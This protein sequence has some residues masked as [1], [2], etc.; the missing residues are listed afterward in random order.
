[1]LP[2]EADA[3]VDLQGV[4]SRCFGRVA[5]RRQRRTGVGPSGVEGQGRPLDEQ[6]GYTYGQLTAAID[7]GAAGLT[8]RGLGRGDVVVIFSPNSPE[9]PVVFH[10]V[11][12]VGAVASP[13]NALY[14][15]TE[16]AHQLRDAGARVLFTS[17]DAL[18]R[19]RKS[20]VEA[21]VRGELSQ[22][23]QPRER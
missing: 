9:Y 12:S 15:P 16:L 4:G 14:T 21:N 8:E 3:A 1:M 7:R 13:A 10:G 23:Q 17:A 18:D 11:V 19:E 5:R 6:H 22:E 20:G 2:G